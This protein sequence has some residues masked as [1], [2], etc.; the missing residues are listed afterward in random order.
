M[1]DSFLIMSTTLRDLALV[2][3]HDEPCLLMMAF[4]CL[5]AQMVCYLVEKGL[6]TSE[7]TIQR[8]RDLQTNPSTL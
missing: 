1:T 5:L 7:E 8:A 4:L 3:I 6:A 2:K